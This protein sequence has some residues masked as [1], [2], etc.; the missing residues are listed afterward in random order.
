MVIIKRYLEKLIKVAYV[1]DTITSDTAG[2]E[3]QLLETIRRIDKNAFEVCLVCL[4]E[5]DWMR[6]NE[7]PCSCYILGYQGFFS[8][9]FPKVVRRLAGIISKKQIQIV[10]TFF[11]DSIFVAWAG[12]FLAKQPAVLLSSRRD[13]GLGNQNQPWYHRIY[14]LLLPLVN[15]RFSGIIA[16]SQNVRQYAAKREKTSADKIKVI[17]NGIS[18]PERPPYIP[19]IFQKNNKDVWIGLVS[20]LTPVKRH[21]LLIKAYAIIKT[22]MP[23]S[24]VQILF[25]GA[26]KERDKLENMVRRLKVEKNIHFAGAVNDVAAYLYQLDIG[27]LCSDR[28][29]LS[30]AI[31]EYMACA[32][33]VVATHAGGNTELVD[34]ENGICVPVDDVDALAGALLQ[35]IENKDMRKKMGAASIAKIKQ[36]YSWHKTMTDLEAYYK[37]F[38]DN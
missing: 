15:K 3:K 12:S 24:N 9:S 1:I 20:S 37:S 26:G 13:M 14:T 17:Y 4:R 29:G 19:P 7:L 25:L 10:Q 8:F 21:D 6:N 5:S 16:N 36:S 30:N 35:L 22:A 33:P 11:E 38:V 28:E 34:K 18:I 32:L 23:K 31:L 27:V 2:T